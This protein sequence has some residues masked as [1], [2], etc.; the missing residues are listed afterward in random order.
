MGERSLHELT[1]AYAIDALSSDE[2]R[3]YEEHLSGCEACREELT[4]L[5]E[6]SRALAYGAE[7]AEPPP[8]LRERILAAAQAE[9]PRAETQRARL[10]L[11]RPRWAYPTLAFA[12][13]AACAALAFGIWATTLHSRLDERNSALRAFPL[14]GAAGSLVVGGNG[15][16]ELVVSG[17]RPAPA[18]KT[19]EIWV[20]RNGQA[21]PAGL[22][23]ANSKTV[24]VRLQRS[25]PSGASVAVTVE[26]AGG[27]QT[28]TSKPLLSSSSA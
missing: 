9:R 22:F 3:E 28:P 10:E 8:A 11:R 21:Y 26:R 24:I 19:Y 7:P 1:A 12:A 6:V 14:Q 18:G 25:L 2:A 15:Q 27:S 5:Q 13:V 23:A 16:A 20:L 17:L 4:R